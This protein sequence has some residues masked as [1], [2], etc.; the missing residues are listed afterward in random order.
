M[1]ETAVDVAEA[2]VRAINAEDVTALRGLMTDDH[3]FVDALGNRFSG[4]E[5]MVGGWRHFFQAYPEYRIE[6]RQRFA[7]GAKV[8]LFGH[9]SGKWRVDGAVTAR[10]WGV[11]AAWLAEVEDGRVKTWSVFCDTSWIHP[12]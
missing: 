5:T 4:A 10:S 8:G 7:D 1:A 3:T 9:A 11:A 2:F 6:V 12:R